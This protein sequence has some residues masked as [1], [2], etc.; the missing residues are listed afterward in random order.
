MRLA[1]NM[2]G[3]WVHY[4]LTPTEI[5]D[6]I[7]QS[8][9]RYVNYAFWEMD[10]A[11]GLMGEKWE[12]QIDDFLIGCRAAGVE[13]IQAHSPAGN[14]LPRHSTDYESVLRRTIRSI[15]CCARLGVPQ[16]VIHPGAYTGIGPRQFLEEN[17]RYYEDLLPTAESTGV[18]IL[19]ENIGTW[20]DPYHVHDGAELRAL[21]DHIGHPLV[22]ACW[23]TG[24]GNIAD[25][26]QYESLTQI[27]S[28]LKGVH[29]QDNAGPFAVERAPYRQ[30]LHTLP[31]L[32][33]VNFD[34]VVQ[35]LIDIGYQGYFTFEVS[36][37][38]TYD[39]RPFVY[40][41]KEVQKLEWPSLELC[42][43][44][45]SLLYEIGKYILQSYEIFD[46]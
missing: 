18:E 7:A 46:E 22:G 2:G 12:Q 5:V 35:G 19:V 9:F 14:P 6:G 15:E 45:H 36:A 20:Q 11:S 32:G 44:M 40:Q 28:L 25:A 30:D 34:A 21:V 17:K 41:G 23:D 27:G 38:R 8:G 29:I 31:F 16:I 37:P 24:H 3:G 4:G 1:T 26:D 43:Q 10:D 33:S 39:R 42:V 13:V